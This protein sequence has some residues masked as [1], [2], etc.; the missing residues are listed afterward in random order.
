MV[1]TPS[2]S[3][4]GSLGEW[5]KKTS[6]SAVEAVGASSKM[7][8]ALFCIASGEV[9]IRDAI[10]SKAVTVTGDQGDAERFLSLFSFDDRGNQSRLVEHV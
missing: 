3:M 1:L 9:P 6:K 2:N 8:R 4:S 5:L 10:K 7:L